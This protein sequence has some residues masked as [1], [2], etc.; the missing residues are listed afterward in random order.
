MSDG[1][2]D[3]CGLSEMI[4]TEPVVDMLEESLFLDLT[5]SMETRGEIPPDP[6]PPA[7]TERDGTARRQM[8]GQRRRKKE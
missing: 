8:A 3:V 5:A 1:A 7:E 2:R 4:E 6:S